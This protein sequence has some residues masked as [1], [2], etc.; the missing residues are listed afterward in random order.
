MVCTSLFTFLSPV[1][2]RYSYL[3]LIGMRFLIGVAQVCFFLNKIITFE[4]LSNIILNKGMCFIVIKRFLECMDTPTWAL[5]SP[6]HIKFRNL[7]GK[8]NFLIFIFYLKF[9]HKK[10]FSK[11]IA[12]LIG[13]ILC[14]TK[15]LGWPSVFYITGVKF[16][17]N[18]FKK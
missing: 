10:G 9:N 7:N 2:A 13:G 6:F 15:G 14:E 11:A 18:L 16:K 5:Y 3:A 12:F 8:C 1:A 4:T 17:S